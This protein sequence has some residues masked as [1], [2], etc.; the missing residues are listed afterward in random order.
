M[1]VRIEVEKSGSNVVLRGPDH[2]LLAERASAIGGR[3]KGREW[4][5]P[6]AK[7]D[8]VR[9]LARELWG[10]DGNDRQDTTLRLD[11]S[12][13]GE[14]PMGRQGEAWLAGRLIAR[15]RSFDAPV[16]LGEGVRLVTGSFA[17][18]G[19]SPGRP[20][21]GARYGTVVDIS[22]VP[23]S[24]AQQAEKQFPFEGKIVSGGEAQVGAW[25]RTVTEK[26]PGPGSRADA[27]MGGSKAAPA[28]AAASS[29]KA[30]PPA[31]AAPASKPAPAAKAAPPAKVAP[32]AKAAP[33]PKASPKAPNAKVSAKPATKPVA[34]KAAKVAA[35]K[36][37]RKPAVAAPVSKKTSKKKAARPAAAPKRAAAAKKATKKAAPAA[38]RTAA[39]AKPKAAKKS[40]A[41]KPA[42]KKTAR[43][44]A[45]TTR[46]PAAGGKK[47]KVSRGRR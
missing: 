17:T 35:K 6:S 45:K 27:K 24:A 31:K 44:A 16:E 38:R 30:A 36:A 19:G 43:P 25:S 33:A 1:A 29:S 37:T 14:G 28:K 34:K 7:E 41:R 42:T 18:W 23:L 12:L 32:A 26:I 40:A 22:S 5:F 8:Q 15:R 47:K 11:L 3:T 20:A 39:K 21:L 4:A 46:R 2:P 10:T 9:K 13:Y